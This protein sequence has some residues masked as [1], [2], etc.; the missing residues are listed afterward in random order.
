MTDAYAAITVFL[1][2][3]TVGIMIG[4]AIWCFA[5]TRR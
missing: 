2:S 4:S 1:W 3:V 5:Q